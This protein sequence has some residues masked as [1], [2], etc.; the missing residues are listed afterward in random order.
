MQSWLFQRRRARKAFVFVLSWLS[1]RTGI[2]RGMERG[3]ELRGSDK[4]D[5]P[6]GLRAVRLTT[7][8]PMRKSQSDVW[9][10]GTRKGDR[11]LRATG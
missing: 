7:I 4:V 1:R 10:E 2:G 3:T 9:R 8:F 11:R 6:P 5:G